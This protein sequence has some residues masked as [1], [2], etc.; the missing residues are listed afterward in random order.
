M[1]SLPIRPPMAQLAFRQRMVR[2]SVQ[3]SSEKDHAQTSDGDSAI[4]DAA[5]S[6]RLPQERNNV[7]EDRNAASMPLRVAIAP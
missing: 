4:P 6:G 5:L 3:R 1:K 7:K 2:K